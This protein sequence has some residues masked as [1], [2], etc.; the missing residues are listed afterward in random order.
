LIPLGIG[1]VDALAAFT[2]WLL[3]GVFGY[4]GLRGEIAPFTP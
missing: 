2:V 4:G 1:I 3:H